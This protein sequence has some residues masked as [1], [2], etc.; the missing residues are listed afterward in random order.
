MDKLGGKVVGSVLHPFNASDFSSYLLQAQASKAK[1]IVAA[2]SS[3]DTINTMKQAKEFQIGEDGKQV[4]ATSL[5]FM[6]DIR[7]MGLPIAQKLYAGVSFYWDY[8]DS[9]RTFARRFQQRTGFAPEMTHAGTYSA[10]LHYLKA[11]QAAGSVEARTVTQKMKELPVNDFWN[12]N[13]RVRADGRV[14]HDFH[15]VQVKMPAESKGQF[16]L[17]KVISDVK[18]EDAFPSIAEGKCAAAKEGK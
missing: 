2:N 9:T 5:L 14:L 7:A 13:V 4:I 16:D 1:V 8:N 10:V 17:L 11:V 15:L 18:G 3:G 12:N 6:S